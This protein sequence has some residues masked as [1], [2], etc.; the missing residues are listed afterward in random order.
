[1][2]TIKNIIKASIFPLVIIIGL[3]I[4]NHYI[5]TITG[6]AYNAFDVATMS[7]AEFSEI[8]IVSIH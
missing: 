4:L 6:G 5:M 7:S 8:M 1:M 2:E 3:L